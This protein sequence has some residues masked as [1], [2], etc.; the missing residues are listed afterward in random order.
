MDWFTWLSKTE[1]DPCVVYEYALTFTHNEL[2]QDDVAYF[3]HEF[4]Q[5]M[6]VSIAKHR[7]EILKLARKKKGRRSIYPV[8]WFMLAIKQT[9]N[10][11]VK[12]IQA[13]LHHDRL[14]LSVVPSRNHSL[15][16]KVSML[17]R[18][19]RLRAPPGKTEWPVIGSD[20]PSFVS[21]PG[22][23]M[24][25]NGS[26]ME[27]SRSS[28]SSQSSIWVESEANAESGHITTAEALANPWNSSF[29]R[30]TIHSPDRDYWSSSTEEIKWDSMF[31]NLKPT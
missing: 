17:Q 2:G 26:P 12:H 5:S 23:L 1:L 20:G 10:Y 4:L 13:L 16:W 18:N 21:D 31:K 29:S 22:I 28:G 15:R 14:P 9:K 24:L 11:V 3:S 19:K 30:T 25:T 7:L 8:L 27:G 6:G